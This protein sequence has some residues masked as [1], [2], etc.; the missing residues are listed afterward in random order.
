L[1][2]LQVLQGCEQRYHLK[3][4]DIDSDFDEETQSAKLC[5]AFGIDEWPTFIIFNPQAFR[6][7]KYKGPRRTGRDLVQAAQ[8]AMANSSA[9]SSN[10]LQ[11][12]EP[13]TRNLE[14]QLLPSPLRSRN[15]NHYRNNNDNDDEAEQSFTPTRVPSNSHTG[16]Q[17]QPRG[18]LKMRAQNPTV[19]Y[20]A[21]SEDTFPHET[22]EKGDD[23]QHK[24]DE[25]HY[26]D[27][28][29]H[30][31][32]FKMFGMDQFPTVL[33]YCPKMNVF[34]KYTG[35]KTDSASIRKVYD[36]ANEHCSGYGRSS[37]Q[38]WETHPRVEINY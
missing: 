28:E 33:I 13:P 25:L 22:E 30:S 31:D 35:T 6:F 14:I 16:W 36:E 32:I 9:S 10:L 29:K 38:Q 17:Q 3:Q 1:S 26:C 5:R 19:L 7:S 2:Q 18:V 23:E 34:F 4:I 11:A 24:V 37:M 15:S 20:F 27:A 21:L 8:L 12:W